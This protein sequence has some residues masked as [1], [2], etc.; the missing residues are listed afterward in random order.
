MKQKVFISYAWQDRGRVEEVLKKLKET[1]VAK[2][3]P[4]QDIVDPIPLI[5]PGQDLRVEIQKQ[6][7]PASVVVVLWT[8]Q[9]AASDLVQYEVGMADALGKP[10]VFVT[11]ESAPQLPIQIG[12]SEVVTLEERAP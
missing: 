5:K 7:Q 9:A 2:L 4:S 3:D 11:D 12:D 8:K 10:V 6:M 1:H